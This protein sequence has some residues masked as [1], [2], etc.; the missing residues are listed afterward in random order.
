[1]H[2][3]S[4]PNTLPEYG[5]VRISDKKI[6]DMGYGEATGDLY[7]S[8][9]HGENNERLLLIPGF[10]D[11]HL[12][13]PQFDVIGYDGMKL[14]DWLA[15]A[16]FPAEQ[17]WADII[18]AK[19]Q[20]KRVV[21][22]LVRAGTL[23]CAAFLTSHTN[24]VA[25]AVE[26]CTD[27]PIRAI[28]GRVMMDRNVPKSMITESYWNVQDLGV[29]PSEV[30]E[31]GRV[32]ISVT[33]R[34]A[35]SCSDEALACAGQLSAGAENNKKYVHTHL[36]ETVRECNV[37][38]QLFPS[39]P[40]YTHVYDR[41]KLLHD[42]TLLAHAVHLSDD[43]LKLIALRNSVLVHC[44]TANIFLESGA[45][46]LD[47]VRQFG[48]RM[49]LGSDIAAGC[50]MSMPR[51]ARAMIE[52]A[53][54]RR[55]AAGTSENVYIPT[56]VEVWDMITKGNAEA[57]GW[58]DAGRIAVGAAADLLVLKLPEY[59]DLSDKHLVSRLI[60]NWSDSFIY[61]V[62]LAGEIIDPAELK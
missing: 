32:D 46:D 49:A 40:D 39:D 47:A 41:Y 1:M 35:V 62:I 23:G 21:R 28:L 43:E 25:C 34:F 60:Y 6:T 2:I 61:R 56:P 3:L 9:V 33:P 57:L 55:Y 13:W 17:K 22:N 16:V 11:A 37:V 14:L 27:L 18:F 7:P 53:K 10:I 58:I 24:A 19:A 59:I 51:V 44:P 12:H 45:F 52:T 50:E 29:L 54:W 26:A 42:K 20:A 30:I 8:V 31:N 15:Y 5:W 38:H 36:A 48:V 4:D